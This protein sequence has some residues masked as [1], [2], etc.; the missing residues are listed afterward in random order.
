[1]IAGPGR[2]GA[3]GG[4]ALAGLAPTE[5]RHAPKIRVVS[6]ICLILQ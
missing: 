4:G 1:M 3:R 2:G 5:A 6:S